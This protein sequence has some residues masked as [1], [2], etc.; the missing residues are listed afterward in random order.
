MLAGILS[1]TTAQAAL[2]TAAIIDASAPDASTRWGKLGVYEYPASSVA[3]YQGNRK[4]FFGQ[5][6]GFDV[7]GLPPKQECSVE[8]TFLSDG[9]RTLSLDFN[10]AD[11]DEQLVRDQYIVKL[12]QGVPVVRKWT[13]PADKIS[14]GTLII[15]I[16]TLEGPNS[17]VQKI[18]ICTVDGKKPVIKAK[19]GFDAIT[20]AELEQMVMPLP[21]ITPRPTRVTGVA[22]PVMTL[23]GTW[24]F[25][26]ENNGHFKPIAVPAEWTMQGF[27]VPAGKFALYRK[28]FNVP[29][30]WKG[31]V[32][33]LRF[34]A[35]H[36][37]CHVFLNGQQIGSHIGGFVPF[38]LDATSAIK[39]GVPN[40][41]EVQVQCESISDEVSCLSSYA[42]HPVGGIV[43]K[44]TLFAVPALHIAQEKTWTTL[45]S[46][47]RHATFHYEADLANANKTAGTAQLVLSLTD[48][49]GHI[50]A[51]VTQ[52]IDLKSQGTIPV[53]ATLQIPNANLWTSETPNL[54]KFVSTLKIGDKEIAENAF[55]VGLRQIE[56]RGNQMFVN[57]MPV[58]LPGICRHEVHPLLGRSLTPE[59]C[60]Q[61]AQLY[62]DA[63]VKLVRTSHYPPSEEFLQACDEIGL[64]VEVESAF[65]WVG[66]FNGYWSR[67]S[68]I[69]PKYFPYYLQGNLDTL[70]AYRNHPSVL[71]WSM[72]NES[73]WSHLWRKVMEVMKRY[74]QSRPI[75]FH[76]F[77][78]R[79]GSD[80]PGNQPDIANCHYPSERNPEN[81]S[82]ETRPTWFG[83]YAH[84]QCYNRV[85]LATDPFIQEDWGRPLQR[86]VDL[87]W[88]QPGCLGGA[89]W[90]GIDDVFHLPD[91]NLCG[92]GHWGPIDGWRRTKPEYHGLRMAYTPVRFFSIKAEAGQ[93]IE[94]DLQNRQNFLD[95]KDNLIEWKS[96]DKSGR[97]SMALAPHAKGKM[98]IPGTFKAGEQ[99]DLTVKDPSGRL[100]AREI[101]TVATTP[102]KQQDQATTQMIATKSQLACINEKQLPV[103]AI[104]ALNGSGGNKMTNTVAVDK[105]IAP[106]TWTR[107]NADTTT[108]RFNGKGDLGSGTLEF[109]RR[110]DG[111]ILVRY[112][113]RL[114]K[115]INPRQWGLVFT[116][117]RDFDTIS[118]KR[119]P[120]WTW[121]PTDHI[122]RAIG[123]AQANP[124]SRQ[125]IEEPRVKPVGLWKDYSNSMGSNDFRSTKANIDEVKL[126][127]REKDFVITP[128]N[129]TIKQHVR[130]WVDGNQI[131]VLVAG[132]NTGGADRF[133]NTHYVQERRPL[134]A[135][136]VIGSEFLIK[137]ETR[138]AQ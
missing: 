9:T 92:Y 27:K 29:A 110:Q 106:W 96:A 33:R 28:T 73:V 31:Q 44:V 138:S 81:W 80:E 17:V 21:R 26:A 32:V 125:F 68:Y 130:A 119:Q 14:E 79:P 52:D 84:L 111:N 78:Y 65:C 23:N 108:L 35:V 87:I 57:G 69:N 45:D 19:K 11:F 70:A 95:M 66:M 116:L 71:F 43:R 94:I 121:Y 85:E 67:N 82:K 40:V 107:D 8:A 18:E 64:F 133:F 118:W 101:I 137:N 86:M 93:P 58:K 47:H 6:L 30:D 51:S 124:S 114:A 3:P 63:N 59:L 122:G 105:D 100:I 89:I 36:S 104:F 60:R 22:S 39:P 42:S 98:T 54:Y 61:D 25:S 1:G 24:E 34:D 123:Q 76:E 74:E 83:E 5:P 50:A 129:P 91:G 127:N 12:Q 53:K 128:S 75:A 77:S 126:S 7:S 10:G 112:N 131:R 102:M 15:D 88:E 109:Q 41:L 2:K 115:D 37:V 120:H 103:P 117:P 113:I 48:R 46:T 20:D 38:E 97:I 16:N 135:G 90:S 55:N 99:I 136:D 134:R 56:L 4:T 72:A 62:K 13:I 132:F 49:E